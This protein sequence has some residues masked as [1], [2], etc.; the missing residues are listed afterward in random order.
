MIWAA[1]KVKSPLGC[2]LGCGEGMKSFKD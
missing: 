1:A 2:V